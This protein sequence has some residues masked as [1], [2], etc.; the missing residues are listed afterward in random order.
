MTRVEALR[1]LVLSLD[2]EGKSTGEIADIVGIPASRVERILDAAD[3]AEGVPLPPVSSAPTVVDPEPTGRHR[4][5]EDRPPLARLEWAGGPRNML[6]LGHGSETGYAHHRQ[7]GEEPCDAC[8][9]ARQQGWRK[10]YEARKWVA[11]AS[12]KVKPKTNER[13]E[14]KKREAKQARAKPKQP[15]QNG[16]LPQPI[17][18]GTS[19][20]YATHVKRRDPVC[21]PCREAYNAARQARRRRNRIAKGLPEVGTPG[22]PKRE[23]NHG[24]DTGR[25]QHK[26]RGEEVCEE[27]KV[28]ARAA[29]AERKNRAAQKNS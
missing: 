4:R 14:P 29:W 24:T 8:L 22:T 16:P 28:G 12:G 23:I 10:A 19:A 7:R 15:K 1:T 3:A 18:H 2:D 20:G 13:A 17:K 25:R 11:Q 9:E 21:D 26:R 6:S 27:C 5:T